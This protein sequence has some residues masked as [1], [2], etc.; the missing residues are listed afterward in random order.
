MT[1]KIVRQLI[2]LGV[3]TAQTLLLLQLAARVEK[4]ETCNAVFVRWMV[5]SRGVTI[6]LDCLYQDGKKWIREERYN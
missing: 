6:N 2:L 1:Y 3:V 5:Y 4:A